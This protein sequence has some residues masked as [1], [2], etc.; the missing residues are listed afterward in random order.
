RIEEGE[1]LLLEAWTEKGE[2]VFSIVEF[3]LAREF[4]LPLHEPKSFSPDPL[5]AVVAALGEARQGEVALLQVLFQ[6][7]RAPWPE[8]IVRSVVTPSGEPFFF[9][10]PEL[11]RFAREKVSMPLF[12]AAVRV[13]VWTSS[14]DRLS[15]LLRGLFGALSGS[16]RASNELVPL[17]S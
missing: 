7:A 4:M 6:G 13:A 5:T 16:T 10:A 15:T 3:G 12:A 2:G 14:E 17:G 8:S 9:N 11:T 1:D